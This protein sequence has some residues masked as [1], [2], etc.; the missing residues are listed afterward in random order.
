VTWEV[1]VGA[2]VAATRR[3]LPLALAWALSIHK[4]QGATLDA[5]AVSLGGVF[6]A[7][8]AYVA[9]SRARAL[10]AVTLTDPFSPALGYYLPTVL[11]HIKYMDTNREK[12]LLSFFP[13]GQ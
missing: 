12:G 5:A 1:L 6:E 13:T 4:A 2:R 10:A 7:G 11:S 8:Q 3:Q 9:L